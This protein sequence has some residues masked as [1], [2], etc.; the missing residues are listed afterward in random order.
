MT[1]FNV[2]KTHPLMGYE[3]IKNIEFP[4]PV[5]KIVLQHH[6]LMDGSGYPYGLKDNQI[7]IEA[8]ILCLADVLEAMSTNRPYRTS[9]GIPDAMSEVIAYRGIRYDPGAVDACVEL[10]RSGEFSWDKE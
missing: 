4:W 5:A 1:E 6:E 8:K 9:P 10:F 7:R 2:I 3:I